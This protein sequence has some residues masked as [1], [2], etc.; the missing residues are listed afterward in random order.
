MRSRLTLYPIAAALVILLGGCAVGPTYQ[1]P[2]TPEVSSYKEAEGW[3]P[4]APADALERGPWWSLF[5]DPVLDRL[6]ARVEVS[7][8]NV[9]AAVAA[10]AQARALVREQRASLFPAVTLG[11]GAT[12]SGSGGSGGSSSSTSTTGSSGGRTGNNYQLSIGGSWEPDVWGRLGRAVDGATAGAQASAA[13]LASAKLSAQGELAINYF[14]LR[15]LDAQKG[16]LE[17]TLTGY[18]RALEIAQ[19]RYNAGIV[20]KTDVL[21]AQTQLANAQADDAGLVRQR[22]QLEHAIAVL[23]GEAPGNF[24]L[25][26]AAWKPSVPEVPVGVPSTLL[27]RRPDIAAAERRV[28]AANEQIGIAKSAYYPNLSLSAS[29]GFGASRV[30][31]LFSASSTV[32]SLGLS[33][34]QV[35]FNAGATGARVEGS[36][37]AHAQTVARYRQTVLAAFQDVEDQL[38][39][40]RVLLTQQELRRQASASADQVEQ[41]VLNRYRSG[42]VGYTEVIAAQ[43]TAL[44][45]RRA[46]VQA[47]ADRQTTAVALIQ[48]LGGGWQAEPSP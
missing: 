19:N 45:A 5:G 40:T 23:I 42:Q 12:R 33:A 4:A 41:Q 27:Q 44:S 14:S 1:R 32:W 35:L 29:Y 46:L 7:N 47:M 26:R 16:L 37:A 28:A 13:D 36:E 6:A 10:Y 21:Q 31:D 34:A 22:A 20:G 38:A 39:A 18:Q 15:Q 48:S 3:V 17:D 2:L 25:A 24:S 9:A 43:A 30:A 11:G 8:Q